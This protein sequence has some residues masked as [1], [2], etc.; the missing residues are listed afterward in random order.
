MT[1]D[2]CVVPSSGLCLIK[3]VGKLSSNL[4][5][6][7]LNPRTGFS[8]GPARPDGGEVRDAG[9]EIRKDTTMMFLLRTAFWMSVALALL[10]SF[11]PG[12]SSTV[13]VDLRAGEAVT[14]ASATVADVSLFCERRPEA[15][16]AGAQFASAF[17]QRTQAGAKILYEFVGDR[18]GKSDRPAAS[19]D[20]GVDASPPPR[21]SDAAKPSRT[22]LTSTDMAP[23]WRGPRRDGP[24]KRP[25]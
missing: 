19:V 4:P 12:R 24:G 9:K 22:T 25:T 1:E 10:P 8:T 23:A 20:A 16:A 3:I 17:G 13:P 7:R 5:P 21:A 14:A 15:C 2:R 11:A 18:I 6:I